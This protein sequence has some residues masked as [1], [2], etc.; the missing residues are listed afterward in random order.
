M[1]TYSFFDVV[2]TI[3]GPGGSFPLGNTAQASEEGITI[4][5]VEDK[6]TMTIGADG[7]VMHSLHAGKGG[8]VTVRLLK[9]SPVNQ[10]LSQ[11]YSLQ[12][13]SSGLHGSNIIVVSNPQTGDIITCN[14]VAFSKLPDITYAKEGGMNE[15]RFNVGS[16][17]MGLGSGSPSL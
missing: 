11:M 4:S 17:D 5:M 8:T 3:N 6:D 16:V 15:W 2:A 7:A 1:S 9:T 10:Q 12:T 13:L 14:S